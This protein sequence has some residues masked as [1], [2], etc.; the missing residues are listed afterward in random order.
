M[1]KNAA[2][3]SLE[4]GATQDDDSGISADQLCFFPLRHLAFTYSRIIVEEIAN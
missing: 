4:K 1:K 3:V 2:F